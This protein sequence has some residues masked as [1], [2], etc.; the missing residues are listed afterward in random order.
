MFLVKQDNTQPWIQTVWLEKKLLKRRPSSGKRSVFQRMINRDSLLKLLK[1]LLGCGVKTHFNVHDSWLVSFGVIRKWSNMVEWQNL[2][3][4]ISQALIHRLHLVK[5]LKRK[6]DTEN[7]GET[8]IYGDSKPMKMALDAVPKK[9]LKQ[10][11]LTASKE[12]TNLTT[13]KQYRS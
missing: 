4:W 7:G 11:W 5:C 10:D 3:Q 13:R 9:V 12:E 6:S 8:K 1:G 2:P